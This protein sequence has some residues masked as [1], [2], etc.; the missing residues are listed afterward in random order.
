MDKNSTLNDFIRYAY[1]E[2]ELTDSVRIQSAIDSDPV[3]EDEYLS[4]IR[5]IGLLD[6]IVMEPN[7]DLIENILKNSRLNSG[8]L[9]I[10]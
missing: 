3:I 1:N 10:S 2:T 4:L 8:K 5:V 9:M 7:S 6:G